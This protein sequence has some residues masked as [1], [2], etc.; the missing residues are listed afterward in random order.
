MADPDQRQGN[1][2]KAPSYEAFKDT[3]QFVN[4][5]PDALRLYWILDGP[6]SSAIWIM[7]SKFYDPST[8]MK[9][10]LLSIS[11]DGTPNWSEISQSPLTTPKISSVTVHVNEL[12][13][14]EE[15]WLEL[16]HNHGDNPDLLDSDDE[17]EGQGQGEDADAGKDGATTYNTLDRP[18]SGN[19]DDDGTGEAER[20][21]GPLPDFDPDSDEEAYASAAMLQWR[22]AAED[23]GLVG[24]QRDGR[25]SDHP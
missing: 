7:E 3:Q 18:E 9:P 25:L 14:W 21:W 5:S 2:Q 16:H 17:G 20:R 8:T 10:Y 12:E 23:E 22:P 15:S 24:C 6:L 11:E 4:L 13:W 19:H 1:S